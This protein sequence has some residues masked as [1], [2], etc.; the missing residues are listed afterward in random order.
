M[1]S[2]NTLKAGIETAPLL[3]M[4]TYLKNLR[5]LSAGIASAMLIAG[6]ILHALRGPNQAFYLIGPYLGLTALYWAFARFGRFATVDIHA[7]ER[8]AYGG[9]EIGRHL[10]VEQIHA[11][12][13]VLI[14]G[15]SAAAA[16]ALMSPYRPIPALFV[17]LTS[18]C[19]ELALWGRRRQLVVG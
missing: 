11:A 5:I 8:I 6:F 15:V 2:I 12:H 14:A 13:M 3:S 7:R 19:V 17:V 16:I 9:E 4:E 1:R 18:V 10:L